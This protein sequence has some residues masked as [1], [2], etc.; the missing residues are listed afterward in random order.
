MLVLAVSSKLLKKEVKFM[1]TIL[2]I[3]NIIFGLSL[4]V[5]PFGLFILSTIFM[6]NGQSPKMS[7]VLISVVVSILSYPVIYFL[8][9]FNSIRLLKKGMAQPAIFISLIPILA[10]IWIFSSLN[11]Y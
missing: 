1:K 11:W 10:I 7:P 5:W 9:L 4:L 2:I 8:G 6:S 3:I